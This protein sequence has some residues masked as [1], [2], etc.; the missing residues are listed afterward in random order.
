M[1][2][3][4]ETKCNNYMNNNNES[5]YSGQGVFDVVVFVFE[6]PPNSLGHIETGPRPHPTDWCR[7]GV[8]NIS[9]SCMLP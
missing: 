3:K 2:K 6:R 1:Q 8:K 5:K 4:T 7:F 9:V